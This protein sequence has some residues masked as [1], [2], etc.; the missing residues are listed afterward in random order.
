MPTFYGMGNDGY[1]FDGI[2][3]TLYH[4]TA[5]SSWDGRIICHCT[6]LTSPDGPGT[7]FGLGERNHVYGTFSAAKERIVYVGRR[8]AAALKRKQ[9]DF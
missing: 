3:V 6:L 7:Q 4:G 2:A 1:P 5:M 8:I 9:T